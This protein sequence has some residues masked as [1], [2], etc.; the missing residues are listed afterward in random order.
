MIVYFDDNISCD[1]ATLS[2]PVSPKIMK[3]SFC[4]NIS[5]TQ[6]ITKLFSPLAF[7]DFCPLYNTEWKVLQK[8]VK[9][10]EEMF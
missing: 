6:W 3:L 10:V 5:D 9:G 8:T 2:C 1:K 4:F 7:L